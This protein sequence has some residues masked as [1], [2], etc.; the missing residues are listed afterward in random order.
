[1]T[2]PAIVS[3]GFVLLKCSIN[4]GSVLDAIIKL[5]PRQIIECAHISGVCGMVV[6]VGPFVKDAQLLNEIEHQGR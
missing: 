1:M 5:R 3:L 2:K 4:G 6:T